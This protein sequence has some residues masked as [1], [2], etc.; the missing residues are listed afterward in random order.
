M[1]TFLS[2][3]PVP[4]YSELPSGSTSFN[5]LQENYAP[6]K[7][8]QSLQLVHVNRKLQTLSFPPGL[9]SH[10][11]N[12]KINDGTGFLNK[13]D[14]LISRGSGTLE[15]IAE[16][17]F[18]KYG[19]GTTIEYSK[20]GKTHDLQLETSQSQ[21]F[22]VTV[23]GRPLWYWQPSQQDKYL[24][25]VVTA[26]NGL[27]AQFIYSGE[28]TFV[29]RDVKDDTVLGVLEVAEPY[30]SQEAMLNQL[31]SMTIVLVERSKRRG[32]KLHG[33]EGTR[34][35][36]SLALNGGYYGGTVG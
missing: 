29:G 13:P 32:R 14:L 17:R 22:M 36:M 18:E 31:V 12:V 19:P 2:T 30:A 9:T 35:M 15:K 16:G 28:H 26:A 33:T 4:Q 34:P 3:A 24:V 11:Y 6:M 5:L 25:Q 20:S 7:S 1:S 23:D 21:R 8:G 27:V 10:N